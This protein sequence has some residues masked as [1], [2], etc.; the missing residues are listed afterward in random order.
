MQNCALDHPLGCHL[1]CSFFLKEKLLILSSWELL[2]QSNWEY[3][4]EN[5]TDNQYF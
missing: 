2:T 1:A 5:S 3:C 4:I